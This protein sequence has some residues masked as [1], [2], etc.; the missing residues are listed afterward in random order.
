MCSKS[1]DRGQLELTVR[2]AG[3]NG[4]SGAFIKTGLQK[5]TRFFCVEQPVGF[6]WIGVAFEVLRLI[7]FNL[8]LNFFATEFK[9][10]RT[11]H[12]HRQRQ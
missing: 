1:A 2:D 5:Q 11:D 8:I 3:L 4:T 7:L 9:Q 6:V 10:H 12:N